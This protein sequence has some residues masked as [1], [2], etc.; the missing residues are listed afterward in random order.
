MTKLCTG[1]FRVGVLMMMMLLMEDSMK[2]NIADVEISPSPIV[3]PFV[4]Q[5]VVVVCV[6]PFWFDTRELLIIKNI[7]SSS[8]TCLYASDTINVEKTNKK[9]LSK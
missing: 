9:F 5:L 1:L 6:R 3:L 7:F 2:N 8:R 4:W